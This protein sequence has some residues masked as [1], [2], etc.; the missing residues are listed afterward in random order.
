MAEGDVVSMEEI[1]HIF[2]TARREINRQNPDLALKY[3]RGLRQ[4]IETMPGTLVWAEFR[5]LLGEAYVAK[6]DAVACEYLEEAL[7][8]LEGLPGGHTDLQ[9]RAH[10]GLGASY[11]RFPEFRRKALG[12]Y[13]A[14]RDL[15]LNKRYREETADIAMR[16]IPLDMT[17]RSDPL[18]SKF[19]I[20]KSAANGTDYTREEQL[21][22]WYQYA[23]EIDATNEG[24]VFAR[25][26]DE[27][28]DRNPALEEYFRN[29]LRSV[30][31]SN[32]DASQQGE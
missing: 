32:T 24:R 29:L 30:R 31:E 5:V 25:E 13:E 6:Q 26:A 21:A 2:D 27:I 22:A 14:A 8:A 19:R 23:G 28:S 7:K 16:I 3:L 4:T 9:L 10:R 20:L 11:E 18:L 12:H 1:R 15:G 17:L